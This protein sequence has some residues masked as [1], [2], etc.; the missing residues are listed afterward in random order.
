M[1]SYCSIPRKLVYLVILV[2]CGPLLG[3][4]AYSSDADHA[5]RV[6]VNAAEPNSPAGNLKT[7]EVAVTV[8]DVRITEG[9]V[10]AEIAVQLRMMKIPAQT[11]PET[12]E[13]LKKQLR[14]RALETLIARTLL[15]EELKKAEIVVTDQQVMT[16]VKEMVSKLRL[17]L[18]DF[19]ARLKAT[20]NNSLD[21]WME[22][23]QLRRGLAY[24][25]LFEAKFA[26]QINISEDNAREF[27][28]ENTVL[29]QSPQKVR[30][31][32]ILV[33]PDVNDPNTDPNKASERAKA[34]AEALLKQLKDGADFAE[35]ARA[36]SDCPSAAKGGDLGFQARDA[37][38]APFADAAFALKE[39]QL[40]EVVQTQHGYH[41][42][43]VTGR[44]QAGTIPFE[45][46]KDKI[47]N[48][49]TAERRKELIAAYI[50]S[51]KDEARIVY[52]PGKEPVWPTA[53]AGQ[54]PPPSDAPEPNDTT[55]DE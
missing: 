32:H 1:A 26:G 46:V 49:L 21:D 31:S 39:Q 20:G 22:K 25:R 40:S 16:H 15:D 28:S 4:D 7:D 30:A 42:I 27:Y 3:G 48:Q 14:Y 29:F 10:D 2:V 41:I 34:K 5:T 23:M 24:N 13:I 17:S 53:P 45:E 33:K 36:N 38:V 6:D 12:V 43:K 44:Q 11:Q 52:P 18:A 8:N 50:R 55:T 35:L 51:L 47:I 54:L 19:E 37:W 9:Q